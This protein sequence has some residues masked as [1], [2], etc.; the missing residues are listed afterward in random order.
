MDQKH[1]LTVMEEAAGVRLDQFVSAS[2]EGLSRSRAEKLIEAGLVRVDGEPARPSRKLRPWETVEV[3][4]PP[5]EKMEVVPENIE[6]SIIYEDSDIVVVNK[7]PGMIVHPG[8]GVSGGTL[9]NALLYHCED[10]SG[11]G[12]TLRPGIVHRL[13]KGT[14][15]L[16]IAAKNDEAHL[17]LQQ[18]FSARRVKKH[19]IAIVHGVMGEKEGVISAPIGRHPTD[20]KK[21]S[22]MARKAR[23]AVTRWRERRRFKNFS[24][25]DVFPETGRTHQVRVHMHSLGHPIVG[26]VQYGSRR[27]ARSIEAPRLRKLVQAFPRQALHAFRLQIIHPTTGEGMVFEAPLPEDMRSLIDSLERYGA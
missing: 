6:I 11:V 9:V 10:L 4:I 24:I 16:V 13:D 22:V 14:S 26:D 27:R 8:A 1:I 19:Y 25:L 20:R 15:G 18:Q 17:L 5:P 12:G 7:P 23:Q 2:I 21:M 3:N